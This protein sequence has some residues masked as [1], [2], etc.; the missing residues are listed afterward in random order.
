VDILEFDYNKVD[1]FA[2]IVLEGGL[3]VQACTTD[4]DKININDC[5]HD[6]GLCGDANE[7]AFKKWGENRCME[8]LFSKAK[9]CGFK[10]I[11]YRG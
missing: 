5:G 1:G 4:D 7:E 6:W 8:A 11:N 10:L 3:T 9:E 2:W